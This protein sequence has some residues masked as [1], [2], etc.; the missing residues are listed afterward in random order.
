M[1]THDDSEPDPP[2]EVTVDAV[3]RGQITVVQPRRGYR[4]SI[5]S[6]LLADLVTAGPADSMPGRRVVDLGAG[7]GV[8]GLLVARRRPDAQV[9]LVELQPEMAALAVRGAELSQLQ[10][11]VTVLRADLRQL[12]KGPGRPAQLD[13]A[14]VDLIVSNPPYEP[15]GRGTEN[16]QAGRATARHQRHCAIDELMAAARRLLRPQGLLAV[17]YPAADLPG[18]LAAAAAEKLGAERLRPVASRAGEAATRVMVVLRK[19]GR[20]PLVLE[21][22]LVLYEATGA[23]STEARR[24]L[25]EV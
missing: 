5:D 12:G 3:C 14:T 10:D 13:G 6:L 15:R 17:V 22:A 24:A 16:P 18:L 19:G 2:G 8:I 7:C 9:T 11:R 23:Y 4:F 1:I 21:P 20:R 25:G